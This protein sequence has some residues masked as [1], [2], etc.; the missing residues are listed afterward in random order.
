MD[1]DIESVPPE[2]DKII[3]TAQNSASAA[4]GAPA[5]EVRTC[6]ARCAAS[7]PK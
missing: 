3:I 2:A 5:V 1:H 4:S 6:K 7:S